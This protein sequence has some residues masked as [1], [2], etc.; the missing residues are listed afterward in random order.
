MI[1]EEALSN[2]KLRS[3]FFGESKE[4]KLHLQILEIQE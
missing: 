3:G 4:S 1:V 2:P